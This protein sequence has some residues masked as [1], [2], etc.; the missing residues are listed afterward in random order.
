VTEERQ[1]ELR[2]QI[3]R[4][5]DQFSLDEVRA[6]DTGA[7]TFGLAFPELRLIERE[8]AEQ[9]FNQKMTE[10]RVRFSEES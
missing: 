9:Y 3:D 4:R 5:F 2:Q 1:A 8:F 6:A 7:L 10:L